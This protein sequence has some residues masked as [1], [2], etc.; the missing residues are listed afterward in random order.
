MGSNFFG[1]GAKSAVDPAGTAY[2][3]MGSPGSQSTLGK[4]IMN[5]PV[6]NFLFGGKPQ[7]IP[8]TAGPWAGTGPSLSLANR[9]YA[10]AGGSGMGA[11]PQLGAGAPSAQLNATFG[12]GKW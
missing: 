3:Q 6:H 12:G 9:G 7:A 4:A 2:S 10:T 8:A 11:T 5:D 1:G